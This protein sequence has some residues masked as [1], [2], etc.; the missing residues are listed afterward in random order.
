MHDEIATDKRNPT[1]N[2]GGPVYGVDLAN[3][4]LRVVDPNE[5]TAARIKIPTRDGFKTPWAEQTYEGLNDD[6]QSP[7]GFGTLG[8]P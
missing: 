3:D 7:F 2:A 6:Q 4:Y 1:V 8:S 5:N